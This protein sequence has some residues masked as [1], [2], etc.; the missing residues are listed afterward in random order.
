MLFARTEGLA[1]LLP[2]LSGR[3]WAGC[4]LDICNRDSRK[5]DI[6]YGNCVGH[7]RDCFLA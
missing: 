3:N 2:G 5:A 4:G 6:L 7:L 1:R